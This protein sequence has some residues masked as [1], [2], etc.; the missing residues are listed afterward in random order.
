MCRLLKRRPGDSVVLAAWRVRRRKLP[1]SS[2]H[3]HCTNASSHLLVALASKH[4]EPASARDADGG[5]QTPPSRSRGLFLLRCCSA[6]QALQ[7][8]LRRCS[9]ACR[10][11]PLQ[12]QCA[13]WHRSNA[14]AV[15]DRLSHR[16]SSKY[17][18]LSPGLTAASSTRQYSSVLFTKSRSA[19]AALRRAHAL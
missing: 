19:R 3:A 11:R 7:R 8:G 2:R 10:L 18:S 13:R 15:S 5:T 14:D 12:I 17:L 4:N 9:R 16:P 6:W 1:T